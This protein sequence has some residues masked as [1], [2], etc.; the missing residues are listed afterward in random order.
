MIKKVLLFPSSIYLDRQWWHRFATVIFWAWLA[1]IAFYAFK[2]VLDAF[3]KC[4]E[5]DLLIKQ[6]SPDSSNSC[7]SNAFDYAFYNMTSS[8]LFEW[9]ILLL[10]SGFWILLPSVVYRIV[11]YVAIGTAWKNSE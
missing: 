5:R 7:R 9:M 1:W 4:I 3:E 8:S 11:L 10:L 6:M 2:I